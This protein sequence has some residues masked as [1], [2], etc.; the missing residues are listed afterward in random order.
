[1]LTCAVRGLCIVNSDVNIYQS[2]ALFAEISGAESLG[3]IGAGA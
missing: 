2:W 3:K 1:M